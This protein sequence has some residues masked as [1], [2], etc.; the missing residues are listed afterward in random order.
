[1]SLSY[2]FV[3][4]EQPTLQNYYC[5]D[6]IEERAKYTPASVLGVLNHTHKRSHVCQSTFEK[7]SLVFLW[8]VFLRRSHSRD[9]MGLPPTS[10]RPLTYF[11]LS[12][13]TWGMLKRQNRTEANIIQM[14]RHHRK[15][16][17]QS[18][19]KSNFRQHM[20][21]DLDKWKHGAKV[22]VITLC[23]SLRLGRST[24]SHDRDSKN[25]DLL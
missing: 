21:W 19:I 3:F 25:T 7:C 20:G 8:N 5:E 1:M 11:R 16:V 9:G 12:I 22:V 2:L 10:R 18:E 14:S 13:K 23:Y 24:E 6:K 15:L 4:P 17:S